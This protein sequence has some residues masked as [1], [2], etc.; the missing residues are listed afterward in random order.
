MTNP[1]Y[2]GLPPAVIRMKAR[3][4]R[5]DFR[6]SYRALDDALMAHKRMTQ[7]LIASISGET[8]S[9]TQGQ[10]LQ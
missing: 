7:E 1:L 2:A 4:E 10:P 9:A 5:E 3:R 8:V 6:A